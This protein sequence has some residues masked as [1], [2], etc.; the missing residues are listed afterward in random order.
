MTQGH[1][2]QLDLCVVAAPSPKRGREGRQKVKRQ[3][4]FAS[5]NADFVINGD[6]ELVAASDYNIFS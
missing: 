6:A 5:H 1:D 4:T 3:I 2:F